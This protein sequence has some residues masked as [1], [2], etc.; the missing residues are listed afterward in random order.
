MRPI[1]KKLRDEMASDPYYSSC[2]RRNEECS[3][4]ITW[5]H[6]LTY[7]GRQKNE[8]WAIIPLCVYHHLGDGLVKSINQGI[9][10]A[11][12]TSKDK[13]SYPRLDWPRLGILAKKLRID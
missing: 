3:G 12:A 10:A 2:A 6:A 4:R 13:L 5:E 7:A 1:P 8:K 9:A 11:R